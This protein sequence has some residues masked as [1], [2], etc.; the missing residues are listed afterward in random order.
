MEEGCKGGI[1]ILNNIHKQKKVER[2]FSLFFFLVEV[3]LLYHV[4]LVFVVQ[5]SEITQS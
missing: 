5:E 2:S 1:K 4:V 3:Q